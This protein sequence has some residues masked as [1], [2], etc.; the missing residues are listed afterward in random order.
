MNVKKEYILLALLIASSIA[1]L[2]FE[3]TDRVHYTLPKLKAVK[4][5]EITKIEMTHAGSR[6]ALTKKDD[7]WYIS[8]NNWRADQTKIS[9]MLEKLSGL[10][11][12]DLVS[13]SKTYERYALDDK[14][15]LILKAYSGNVLN[16]E[17]D[18][19]KVATTNQH[20]YIRF[21]GNDKV[22][23][24]SG[25]LSRLFQTPAAELRDMLVF[26]INPPDI[27]GIS[28]EQYGKKIVLN[29]EELPQDK[30]QKK[31]DKDAVKLFIWKD[32]KGA[33]V[34]KAKIDAFLS[35]LSKI[36]GEGYLDDAMKASLTNP[37]ITLKIKGSK[38]YVLS[39]FDKTSE[40]IPALSSQSE[41]PFVFPGYKL[42]TLKKSLDEIAKK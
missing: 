18:V 2:V 33:V 23:L 11:V 14:N 26:S 9:E 16:R 35:V 39:I 7:S 13:E 36:Y 1:Y 38:E 6:I 21:P 27:T 15:K 20:T 31:P 5:D 25:D 17:L 22:Y 24:A 29:R 12:T 37:A 34:D 3:R 28:I 40:K 8:P 19:G 41:S 42:D 32:E 30:S 10:V 4:T